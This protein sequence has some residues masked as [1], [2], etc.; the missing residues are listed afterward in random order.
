M[1][2]E[3]VPQKMANN[4]LLFSEQSLEIL[5]Q[6]FCRLIICLLVHKGVKQHL[7]VS[8]CCKVMHFLQDNIII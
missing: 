4:C 5:T 3:V 6:N 2:L 1:F 8:Y 7:I